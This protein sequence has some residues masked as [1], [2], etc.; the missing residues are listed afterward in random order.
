MPAKKVDVSDY[1]LAVLQVLWDCGFATIREITARVY[2]DV[3]QTQY[4]TVQKLLERLEKKRCVRRH[5]TSPAHRF[6]AR[7]ERSDLISHRLEELAASL[8]EGSLTPLLIHLAEKTQLNDET[9]E[10][11]RKL[12]ESA[13]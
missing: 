5:R 1:E 3:G 10:K 7:I 12:I 2:G 4:A 11:L 13:E 9:R 8:C 6:S